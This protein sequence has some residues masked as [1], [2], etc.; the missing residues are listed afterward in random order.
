MIDL[1]KLKKEYESLTQSISNPDLIIQ[2]EKFQ[3]ISRRRSFLEKIIKKTEEL[4][5]LTKKIEENKQILVSQ[6]DAELSSLAQQELTV[7]EE[8]AKKLEKNI[9][10]LLKK[11]E[12]QNPEALIIEVRPGTG[13][14]EA[15]LFARN[16]F[17][18]YARYAQ[19]KGWKQEVLNLDEKEFGGIKEA[20]L[21]IE[22]E[23]A[24]EKLQYEGG[25]HRV[26]RIPETEKAGRIHTSTASVAI[27]PK[28]KKTQLHISPND[29]KFEFFNSSGP[30][31]QNVNKRK[32]A[33]RLIYLPTNLIIAVQTSRTQQKNKEAAMAILEA[34][35]LEH[36]ETKEAKETSMQR[37]AQ[38]GWAKRAEKIRT[39]NFPQDRITDHRIE[40]SW[41]GIEKTLDG[42]LDPIIDALQ[43]YQELR[44]A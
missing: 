7:I 35:L 40:Q 6:E 32:T 4:E 25:V 41:H 17:D 30:G 19:L 33:V 2:W 20:S 24:F 31:G 9:Q 13:G 8:Q 14:E 28:P 3:E 23:D 22:G 27:L 39:Y 42:N 21:E 5:E 15:S 16:L 26:Q 34:K 12:A 43:E 44:Q 18:M 37:K 10:E 29:L 11:G 36:H 1:E 38:I